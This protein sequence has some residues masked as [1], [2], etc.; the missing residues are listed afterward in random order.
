[1]VKMRR[2]VRRKLREKG[3]GDKEGVWG[4]EKEC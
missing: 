3:E 4:G 1:M 2:M